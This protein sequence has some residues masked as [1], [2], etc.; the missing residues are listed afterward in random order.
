MSHIQNIK[1]DFE[2]ISLLISP[3]PNDSLVL[4]VTIN[5]IH[6]NWS[7]TIDVFFLSKVLCVC[8]FCKIVNF[9]MMLVWNVIRYLGGNGRFNKLMKFRLSMMRWHSI[10]SSVSFLISKL[11]FHWV[12]KISI[13]WK[14]WWLLFWFV[15]QIVFCLPN[16]WWVVYFL[17][18]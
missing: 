10:C 11:F 4:F 8:N 9:M 12:V 7:K 17:E 16:F 18:N 6:M 14:I 3:N 15:C 5:M 1:R 13:D 2:L